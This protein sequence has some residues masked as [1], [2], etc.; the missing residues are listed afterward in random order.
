MMRHGRTFAWCSSLVSLLLPI[1]ATAQL[2]AGPGD[3]PGWRGAD[4]TGVSTETGLLKEW[5]KDG[6]PLVWKVKGLG[7]GYSTPSIAR[8]RIYVMGNQ[9]LENEF[10]QC[11]NVADGAAVWETKVGKVGSPKQQPAYPGSRSTPTVDGDRVYALGSDG[12]LVCLDAATGKEHWKKSL[13]GD[14]GGVA[15]R[16]AFAES[17]LIDG[18]TLVCSPGGPKAAIVTLNKKTGDV[19]WKSEVDDSGPAAYG[20]A[21]IAEGGGVKQY[22]QFLGKGLI[23]VEAKDGKFLWRF[24][25]SS[26]NTNCTTAIFHDG[27][28][29]HAAG[30]ASPGGTALF[31]LT[32][33]GVQQVYFNNKLMNHHG[34]VIRIG[35][36]VY[37]TNNT[38]LVCLDFKTGDVKW[39]ERSVGKGALTAADGHLYVRGE[40]SG[41]VAL[42]EATPDA[43]KEKS[44]F[45]PPDR[46]KDRFVWPHPVVAGGRLYLRD[47]DTLLCYDI[48]AK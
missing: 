23:S 15:G 36:Y 44:R 6:P 46:S 27:Y 22:V 34:G 32:P 42:I 28:V 4:R 18:D 48:K 47:K 16:W 33:S 9:G 38:H 5:P 21:I 1:A 25:K 20:S 41:A 29:F 14:F 17:V 26:G 8:G 10:V 43:Y 37:G 40:Q 7:E 39:Q 12:D 30:G 2:P 35:D 3:W 31:R 19:I 45:T 11:R 13:S 24:D